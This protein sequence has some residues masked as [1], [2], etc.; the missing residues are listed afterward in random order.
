MI[1]GVEDGV[2]LVVVVDVVEVGPVVVDVEVV[3]TLKEELMIGNSLFMER[4][5][6]YAYFWKML[7][8][9]VPPQIS[10]AFPVHGVLQFEDG[11]G[12]PGDS[13]AL[14]QSLNYGGF[15]FSLISFD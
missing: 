14:S 4:C 10:L 6:G 13:I 9:P 11:I 2:A 1:V 8:A 5:K 15:G 7:I 12:T 3:A